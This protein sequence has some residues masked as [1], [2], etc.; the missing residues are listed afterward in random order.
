MPDNDVWPPKPN[1]ADPLTEYDEVIAALLAAPAAPIG[2]RLMLTKALHDQEG[3]E[4]R[5][6]KT[7]LTLIR[8]LCDQEGLQPRHASALANSY[9]QRHGLFI[10]SPAA[11]AFAGVGCGLAIVGLCLAGFSGYL[12]LVRREKILSLPH[13]HAALMALDRQELKIMGAFLVLTITSVVLTFV[14]EKINRRGK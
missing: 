13:H 5:H 1:L 7:K 11:K 9:C 6:V 12:L 3:P 10:T 2:T 4:L 14:R 8:A